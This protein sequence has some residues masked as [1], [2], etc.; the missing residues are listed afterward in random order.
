MKNTTVLSS[1]VK[2][3]NFKQGQKVGQDELIAAIDRIYDKKYPVVPNAKK[4]QT[5]PV[6]RKKK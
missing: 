2:D 4:D 6:N 1:L 5:K 3:P